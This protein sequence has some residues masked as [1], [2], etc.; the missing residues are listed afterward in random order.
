M[1][2]ISVISLLIDINPFTV[3]LYNVVNSIFITILTNI[4]NTQR[5]NC[6]DID[7]LKDYK[8][9]HQSMYEIS[10]AIGRLVAYSALLITGLL[11][12]II[13]FKLLLFIVALSFIPSSIILYKTQREE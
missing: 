3:I 2:I 5:Y 4:T 7:E 9:E 6:M 10:L 1:P 13:W 11:N 12:N 8:I